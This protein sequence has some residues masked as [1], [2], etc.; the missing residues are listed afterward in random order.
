MEP[1]VVCGMRDARG[2]VHVVLTGGAQ[3]TLC[4]SH[5]LM[6]RRAGAGAVSAA[7]LRAWFGERRATKRRADAAAAA[8]TGAE[9]DELAERLSA[10]FA[11][12]RRVSERRA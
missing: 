6:H 1:C 3:V 11:P 2:L 7:E 5:D 4:G 9:V 8:T 12:E 10:A